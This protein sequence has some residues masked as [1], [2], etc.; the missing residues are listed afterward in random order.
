MATYLSQNTSSIFLDMI[1]DFHLLLFL[2]TNEVMPL[3][4]RNGEERFVS[5]SPP[6]APEL[7]AGCHLRVWRTVTQPA[8]PGRISRLG[9]CTGQA[10]QLAQRLFFRAELSAE[11]LK[12]ETKAPT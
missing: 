4:V 2:V 1:S 3:R 8:T 12:S 9:A 11:G 7:L 5:A 10:M 6:R